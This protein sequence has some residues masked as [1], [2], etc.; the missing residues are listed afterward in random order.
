MFQFSLYKLT[1]ICVRI[2]SLLLKSNHHFALFCDGLPISPEQSFLSGHTRNISE[3]W[4][5][6]GS[7]ASQIWMKPWNSYRRSIRVQFCV[8]MFTC[9]NDM[10]QRSKLIEIC[11]IQIPTGVDVHHQASKKFNLVSRET[12]MTLY[13]PSVW[14]KYVLSPRGS[15]VWG[16]ENVSS[17]WV[18]DSRFLGLYV[19]SF[20]RISRWRRLGQPHNS[21]SPWF[22]LR[23]A[24]ILISTCWRTIQNPE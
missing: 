20:R 5:T 4:N 21:P 11:M 17:L 9:H 14:E 7:E 19:A 3:N 24:A 15:L 22:S 18:L 2:S 6:Q 12:R 23:W 13:F 16:Q 1:S 10:I 8:E